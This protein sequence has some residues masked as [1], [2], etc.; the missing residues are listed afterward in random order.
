MVSLQQSRARRESRCVL[1]R[2]AVMSATV[3]HMPQ[4]VQFRLACR[5][6]FRPVVLHV[7]AQSW[8]PGQGGCQM[9]FEG[10]MCIEQD[11]Q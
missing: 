9:A 10:C 4:L 5:H 1:A 8:H 3:S 7:A 6:I 11:A 2:A